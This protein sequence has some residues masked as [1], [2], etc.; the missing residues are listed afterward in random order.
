MENQ[1]HVLSHHVKCLGTCDYKRKFALKQKYLKDRP[2][3]KIWSSG[4]YIVIWVKLVGFMLNKKKAMQV[5]FYNYFSLCTLL[6]NKL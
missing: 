3:L 2:Y 5:I 1:F 6:H 4:H